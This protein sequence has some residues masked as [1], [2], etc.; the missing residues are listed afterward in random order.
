MK[1]SAVID[2]LKIALNDELLGAFY[3][4]VYL[5]KIQGRADCII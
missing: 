2:V 1:Q 4:Q 5:Q 3:Q